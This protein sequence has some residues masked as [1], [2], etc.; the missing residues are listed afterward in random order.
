MV[1]SWL[2]VASLPSKCEP[3]LTGN[4][5]KIE[6]LTVYLDIISSFVCVKLIMHILHL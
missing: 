3:G 5:H 4:T 6:G 1:V 2:I